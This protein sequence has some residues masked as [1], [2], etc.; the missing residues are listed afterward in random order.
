[1]FSV[2]SKKFSSSQTPS[3]QRLNPRRTAINV[4][5][6]ADTFQTLAMRD[7]FDPTDARLMSTRPTAG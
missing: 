5:F 3:A 1:M 6:A 4:M 7:S 2:G